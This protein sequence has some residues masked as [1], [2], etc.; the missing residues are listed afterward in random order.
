MLKGKKLVVNFSGGKDSTALLLKLIEK[1]FEVDQVLRVDFGT[2][3]D[4]IYHHIDKVEKYVHERSPD[5]EFVTINCSKFWLETLPIR[6]YPSVNMRW[7]TGEKV[8]VMRPYLHDCYSCIGIAYDESDR[9]AF[10]DVNSRIHLYPLVDWKMTEK[11][12]LEYCYSLG[13]DW[14]GLYNHQ[15]RVSCYCCPFS[16]TEAVMSLDEKYV[17]RIREFENLAKASPYDHWTCFWDESID[18]R[19]KRLREKFGKNSVNQR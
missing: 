7:C 17:D 5:T 9:C 10:S 16:S 19:R 13:F 14:S 3:Y 4:E 11:D 15:K 6:G 8:R 2:E 1:D 12:C 18:E